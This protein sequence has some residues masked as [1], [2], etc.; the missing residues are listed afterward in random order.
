M[1]LFCGKGLFFQF[2]KNHPIKK[3]FF[4]ILKFQFRTASKLTCSY[5]FHPRN[6]TVSLQYNNPFSKNIGLAFALRQ[7]FR[8]DSNPHR[9]YP[10]SLQCPARPGTWWTPVTSAK[11][12]NRA[13]IWIAGRRTESRVLFMLLFAQCKKWQSVLPCREFRGFPNLDPARRNDDFAQTKL[14]PFKASFEVLQT[15][16]QR[17]KTTNPHKQN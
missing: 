14:N 13:Y 4:S 8:T 15:S 6:P 3:N 1:L 9:R 17:T 12:M 16:K 11:A 10:E 7:P 5:K 2:M